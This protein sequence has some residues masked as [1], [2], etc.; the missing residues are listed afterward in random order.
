MLKISKQ[1][2]SALLIFF[3]ALTILS[4]YH[5]YASGDDAWFAEQSYWLHKEGIIRSEFFKGLLG[6][7]KQLLVSHKLFLIFGAGMIHLFGYELPVLQFVSVIFFAILIAEIIFYVNR[8]EQKSISWYLLAVL[9]LVF[10]NRIL[11]KM[12][13]ENRPEIML[14]ALGFGSFILISKSKPHYW[15]S[16]A[17]GILAGMAVLTHL[18]G[19]I[20]LVAGAGML[21]YLKQYKNA[22]AFSIAGGLVSLLYFVDIIQAE[23][24]FEIWH[25]QFINDPATQNAF[26]LGSKLLVMVT[27]PVMFFHSPEQVALSLLLAFM[28]WNQRQ[29]LKQLPIPLRI[30]S[31]VLVT[32][33][34][35]ITKKN[36]GVY[37][38]L[39]LPFMLVLTYELYRLK[40]FQ[41]KALKVILGIYFIIG[42]YGAV[43]IIYLNLTLEYLPISYQRLQKNIP[44]HKRGFVPLTFFFNEIE[45]YPHLLSHENFKIQAIMSK[46]ESSPNNMDKWAYANKADFILMDYKYRP[47]KFYPKAGTRMLP[48]YHLT[49]FDG[50]FAIYQN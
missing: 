13:F 48:H 21:F 42:I 12:S 30:Y 39:F 49:F 3:I 14:A 16:I 27:Y 17:A 18:N 9:I 46:S 32:V 37:L 23:N 7:E 5:R 20:Y 31:I 44:D 33:F 8:E 25:Y 45:R 40:P 22:F 34:W 36:S 29:F 2:L 28:F 43:Q 38:T 19:V 1:Q 6:W 26:G 24:G 50:R 15:K 41:T 10:S 35:L 47:E 4:Y 11:I